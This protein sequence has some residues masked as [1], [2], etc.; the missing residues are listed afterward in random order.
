MSVEYQ[1]IIMY[2]DGELYKIQKKKAQ[3]QKNKFSY[4]IHSEHKHFYKAHITTKCFFT[5]Q[6]TK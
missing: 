1:E 3:T 5:F 4:K 2:A 6:K